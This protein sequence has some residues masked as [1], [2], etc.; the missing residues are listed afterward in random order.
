MDERYYLN[1]DKKPTWDQSKKGKELIDEYLNSAIEL[2][3]FTQQP[4]QLSSGTTVSEESQMFL[5]LDNDPQIESP[6]LQKLRER[7]FKAEEAISDM[8]G[9]EG[10][11]ITPRMLAN[12]LW[13]S[14][15]S[16]ARQLFPDYKKADRDGYKEHFDDF[17]LVAFES[18]GELKRFISNDL[19]GLPQGIITPRLIGC[20]LY[21]SPSP[22]DR[23]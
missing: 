8:S 12:S 18:D 9:D 3:Q 21:T 2:Y 19:Q 13:N 17:G 22:R 14:G 10:F 1:L 6:E 11:Y 20:L 4:Q 7:F 15:M 5:S 23:G 16:V